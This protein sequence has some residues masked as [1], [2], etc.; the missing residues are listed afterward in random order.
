[1]YS[2]RNAL[3][4]EMAAAYESNDDAP[5]VAATNFTSAKRA[6]GASAESVTSTTCPPTF[7]KY[8][9]TLMLNR[10]YRRKSKS[11]STSPARTRAKRSA[12]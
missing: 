9:A 10:G 1:M 6:D 4:S 7:L 11:H 3:T 12:T 2:A 5:R 8:S